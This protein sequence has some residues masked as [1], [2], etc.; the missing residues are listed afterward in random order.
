MTAVVELAQLAALELG[1]TTPEGQ[2]VIEG[3]QNASGGDC[4]LG[5]ATRR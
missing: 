2:F 1:R 4:C 3:L 5:R